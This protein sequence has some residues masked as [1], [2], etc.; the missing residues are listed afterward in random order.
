M[1]LSR[2]RFNPIHLNLGS[3]N[4]RTARRSEFYLLTVCHL[5]TDSAP[6]H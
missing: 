6:P 5:I 1:T 4:S 2:D 3:A